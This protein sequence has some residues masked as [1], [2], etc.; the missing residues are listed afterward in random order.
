MSLGGRDMMSE[1]G[2]GGDLKE[3]GERHDRKKK[4]KIPTRKKGSLKKIPT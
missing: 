4:R 3:G 1:E 2:K